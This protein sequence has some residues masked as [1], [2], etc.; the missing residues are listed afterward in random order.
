MHTDDVVQ[1]K[2]FN[3]ESFFFQ[4]VSNKISFPRD[5]KVSSACRALICKILAPLKTRSRISDLKNDAWYSATDNSGAGT[6]RDV[7]IVSSQDLKEGKDNAFTPC[8]VLF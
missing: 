3:I 5:P 7:S 1:K 6:S 4:Q 2:A 8:N